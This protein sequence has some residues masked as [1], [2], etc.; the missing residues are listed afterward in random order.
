MNAEGEV[1][2]DVNVPQGDFLAMDKR[3]RAF[4]AGFGSG[5][6]FLGCTAMCLAADANPGIPQGYFA[7]TYPQIRDIF[8][9]TMEEVAERMGMSIRVNRGDHE[10]RL[11]RDRQVVSNIICRSMEHPERIVGFKIGRGL[12]DEMDVMS[13]VKAR[14]AWRKIIA[15]LRWKGPTGFRPQIDVTTTPE[16]FGFM[17]EQWVKL[18][19]DKPELAATYGMI[20][21]STYDNRE[22]LPEG[23]IESLFDTYPAELIEAYLNGQFVNMTSGTVYSHYNRAANRT[24]AYIQ[25]GEAVHIGMDFN[26]NKMAGIAHIVRADRPAAIGEMVNMRDTPAMIDK[27][28]EKYWTYDPARSDFVRTREIFVYPDASGR[29]TSSKN[30]SLSDIALLEQAGFRVHAP[31]A[32]PPIKDRVLAMNMLFRNNKQERHYMVNDD[33]CPTYAENLEQQVYG[34][35][36]EPDKTANKDHTND[37]GGYFVNQRWPII[38]PTAA[39]TLN[40]ARPGR[41][42]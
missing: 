19:R 13:I 5:K 1:D 3:F 32:N 22:N 42:R 40:M 11:I 16:G 7:P 33:L 30:A 14:L 37:A 34:I 21:A 12:I 41:G 10:V 9:P 35:S 31:A 28:K 25:E 36:G 24:D 17:W 2:F 4:V 27:I 6:T 18:V 15:R 23:Y 26:V 8:Y 39:M 20:Q 29:N 38:K